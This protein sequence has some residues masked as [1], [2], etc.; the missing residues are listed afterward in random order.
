MSK[1]NSIFIL[2]LLKPATSGLLTTVSAIF[3]KFVLFAKVIV[4]IHFQLQTFYS[5]FLFSI[6]NWWYFKLLI[7]WKLRD[8]QRKVNVVLHCLL[9]LFLCSCFI[10]TF[11]VGIFFEV[12]QIITK[13]VVKIWFV[14]QLVHN[15]AYK[16]KCPGEHPVDSS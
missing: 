9:F 6:A 15:S 10:L 14:C 1:Q 4:L 8:K 5:R 11:Q 13:S 12:S 16:F 7:S 3:L 2:F